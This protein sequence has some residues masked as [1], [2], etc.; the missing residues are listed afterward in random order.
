MPKKLYTSAMESEAIVETGGPPPGILVSG[1]FDE[2]PGYR[3][4]RS[5][6]RADW[7]IK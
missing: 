1:H 2:R 7:L 6:G 4:Y 3:A 5:H